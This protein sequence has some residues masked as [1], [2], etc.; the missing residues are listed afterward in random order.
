MSL[1]GLDVGTTGCKAAVFSTDGQMLA[2]AYREYDVRRPLPDWAEL[3]VDDTWEKIKQC[4]REVAPAAKQDPIKALAVSS[5]GEAVV[6]I[7]R[8]RR[9]L[10]A[11]LLNFDARGAEYLPRLSQAIPDEELYNINGNSLGNHYSLT[12]MMWIKEHQPDLYAQTY[13]FLHWSGFVSFMLG[14]DAYVDYS[15]A[16]RTLLFDVDNCTWSEKM[17]NI[18][19]LDKEKLPPTAP[20]GTIIGEMDSH[21]AEELGLNKGIL[22]VTG[23]HDQCANGIGCGVTQ[24]GQ[25]MYGM[26]TYFTAMPV[27]SQR[28]SP[29]KMLQY[30][31]NTEHHAAPGLYVS[32][33]YNHGGSMLKWYRDTFAV[34]EHQQAQ[35]EGR[36]VYP[37]LIAEIPP[38]PSRVLVLPHFAPT[39]P[40]RFISDSS[41]VILGLKLGTPRG[42]ILKAI[43]E[44]IVFY[45][46]DLFEPLPKIG[47]DISGFRAV[48]GGSKS[49]AWIQISADILGKPFVRP[50][51]TEAGALG[52]AIM[53]GSAAGVFSSM[54]EGCQIMVKLDK[55]FEPNMDMHQRYEENFRK[56]QQLY[57]LLETYLRN[58]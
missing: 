31:V 51:V 52:A 17:L 48:G 3:D 53:A 47:I 9:V 37:D 50:A 45:L 40:P 6:P 26:G 33:L 12:K 24:E 21:L 19:A 34:A 29:P 56:Y 20:S 16:N 35:K 13:K 43:L 36:S 14:G 22:I 8:D 42:E 58:T 18:S 4:I 32:F 23:S 49:D 28:K 46:R 57:P 55:S 30:G 38:E 1:L 54:P 5:M 7:T 41:G 25:A 15:L 11:S 2:L 39:G 44:S 27:F 10:G